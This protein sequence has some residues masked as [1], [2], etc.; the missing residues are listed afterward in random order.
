MKHVLN[1]ST[2][3]AHDIL[4]SVKSGAIAVL[5]LMLALMGLVFYTALPHS[6]FESGSMPMVSMALVNPDNSNYGK[7]LYDMLNNLPEI[8]DLNWC[9]KDEA[10]RLLAAGGVSVIIEIPNGVVDA[11]VY[12]KPTTIK[13][14]SHDR[15]SGASVYSAA[16]AAADTMN[17]MQTAVY[18]YYDAAKPLI[19]NDVLF[20]LS[21]NKFCL[22]LISDA[23][24]QNRLIETEEGHLDA[25]SALLISLLVFLIAGCCAL[26]A[27]IYTTDQKQGAQIAR[28]K[29][30]GLSFG[31]FFIGR[32]FSCTLAC[33]LF[34]SII[35][36]AIRNMASELH[37]FRLIVTGVLLMLTLIP[38]FMVI[39]FPSKRPGHTAMIGLSL[40]L[41]LLFTGGGFY[42]AYLLNIDI[43]RF[44]PALFNTQMLT[45]WATG[46]TFPWPTALAS[47]CPALICVLLSVY[48]W[49][50]SFNG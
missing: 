1:T 37:F 50:R 25:Y 34:L 43:T 24:S 14:T 40:L 47:M 11:L 17:L 42:P 33:I 29:L 15:L 21:Y 23:L 2:I 38:V 12:N 22:D 36:L 49:R 8:S 48:M 31:H 28:I 9:E 44:N 16:S 35:A 10:E 32:M 18:Q 4:L 3:I 45:N 39:A 27:G 46:G 41:L 30:R 13:I 19:S 6:I 5:G 26:C 7:I 20:S